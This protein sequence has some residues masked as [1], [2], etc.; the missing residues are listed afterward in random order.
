MPRGLEAVA[1][2]TPGHPAKGRT[3]GSRSMDSGKDLSP[4]VS[5]EAYFPVRMPCLGAADAYRTIPGV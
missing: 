2:S 4:I 5:G 3:P 1:C